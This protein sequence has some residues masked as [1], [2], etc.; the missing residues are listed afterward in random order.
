MNLEDKYKKIEFNVERDFSDTF[1][2]SFTFLRQNFKKLFL[3]LLYLAGPFLLIAAL[4]NS[5]YSQTAFD[6][7]SMIQGAANT[8][9]GIFTPMYFLSLLFT[10]AGSLVFMGVVFEYMVLY[11]ERGYDGFQVADVWKRFKQDIGRVI[12]AFFGLLLVGILLGIGI[13]II[14]FIFSFLGAG[15]GIIIGLLAFV[16]VLIFGLPIGFIFTVVYLIVIKERIGF[17]QALRKARFVLKNNFWITWVIM[18][19]AYLIIAILAIIVSLP[20]SISTGV[21]VFNGFTTGGDFSILLVIL[22]IISVF[23]ENMIRSIFLIIAGFH[24]FS[25]NE[26][27]EGI[28]LLNQIDEIGKSD[29]SGDEI[30][31]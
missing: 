25:L 17:W 1:G 29:N 7:E 20:L 19:L 6:M 23:G 9:F 31:I 26:Q 11:D 2:T 8:P 4:L 24:Y 30:S 16:G 14:V 27:K 21:S 28:G 10:L 15:G 22:T 3:S 18:F 5:I 13:A 12:G